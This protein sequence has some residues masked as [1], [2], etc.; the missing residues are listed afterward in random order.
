M[1]R[2]PSSYFKHRCQV[3]HLHETV[4]SFMD[5]SILIFRF[6]RKMCK[7]VLFHCLRVSTQLKLNSLMSTKCSSAFSYSQDRYVK[8]TMLLTSMCQLY[9]ACD[10]SVWETRFKHEVLPFANNRMWISHLW[11]LPFLQFLILTFIFY[12]FLY[13]QF[14]FN[15]FPC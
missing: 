8:F 15:L 4:D 5:L 1:I 9:A 11:N 6:R 13:S 3:W 12:S 14:P 10:T 7:C 2:I